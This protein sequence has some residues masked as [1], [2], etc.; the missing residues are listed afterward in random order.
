M[1]SNSKKTKGRPK[2][3][4]GRAVVRGTDIPIKAVAWLLEETGLS[5]RQLTRGLG[6][7]EGQKH[8]GLAKVLLLLCCADLL[9]HCGRGRRLMPTLLLSGNKLNPSWRTVAGAQAMLC[10][11]I[12]TGHLKTSQRGSVQNQPP[13]EAA[14]QVVLGIR[15]KLSVASTVAGLRVAEFLRR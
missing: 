1:A 6:L 7:R 8:A 11:V 2:H 14:D 10:A 12:V 4:H 15:D 5:A 13:G 3:E 9:K